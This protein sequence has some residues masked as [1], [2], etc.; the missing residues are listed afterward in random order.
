M[1]NITFLRKDKLFFK[2]KDLFRGRLPLDR[3]L[4][5][6]H[7]IYPFSQFQNAGLPEPFSDLQASNFFF[8]Q[9]LNFKFNKK[10]FEHQSKVL[11]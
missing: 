9:Y 6:E 1:L 11:F 4:K 3:R 8:D 10:R 2:T 7:K 5:N